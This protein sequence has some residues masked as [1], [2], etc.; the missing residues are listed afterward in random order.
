M[1][2]V[3][4]YVLWITI[5]E[6]HASALINHVSTTSSIVWYAWV[7][8]QNLVYYIVLSYGLYESLGFHRNENLDCDLL[9]YD[10]T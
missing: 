8:L 1:A 10:V 7:L 9:G 4:L 5:N 6:H 3:F 2:F